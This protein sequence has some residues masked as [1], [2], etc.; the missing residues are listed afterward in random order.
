MTVE[1]HMLSYWDDSIELTEREDGTKDKWIVADGTRTLMAGG[2]SDD[3][4]LKQSITIA[5]E[6]VD[7]TG[8]DNALAKVPADL[9]QIRK[10]RYS[11]SNRK[12]SRSNPRLCKTD[13]R[14][15]RKTGRC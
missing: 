6:D 12:S 14:N 5:E 3:L 15:R 13:Q 10:H 9:S 7:L 1:K 11:G 8:I 2:A 4:T